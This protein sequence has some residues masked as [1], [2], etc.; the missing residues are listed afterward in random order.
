[1]MLLLAG[2]QFVSVDQLTLF[3]AIKVVPPSLYHFSRLSDISDENSQPKVQ[4]VL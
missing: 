3:Y 4:R 1:M 2:F